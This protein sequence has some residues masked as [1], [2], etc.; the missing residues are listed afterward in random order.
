MQCR[1]ML[2][3]KRRECGIHDEWPDSLALA[4]QVAKDFPVAFTRFE[5]P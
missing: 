4:K 1:S 2:D 3:R 5:D